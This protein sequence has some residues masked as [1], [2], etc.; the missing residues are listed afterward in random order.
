MKPHE[1]EVLTRRL[2]GLFRMITPEQLAQCEAW[3]KRTPLAA[4]DVAGIIA[5]L[6]AEFEYPKLN[7]FA[8]R[9]KAKESEMHRAE[10]RRDTQTIGQ[11][12]RTMPRHAGKT[13]AQAVIDHGIECA[14]K[15]FG[16]TGLSA[17]GV[18]A[19]G[20]M[21]QANIRQGLI[22]AGIP[23]EDAASEA[24]VVCASLKGRQSSPLPDFP[25]DNGSVI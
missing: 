5:T 4:A 1:V 14:E 12:L 8:A 16:A 18:E 7:I 19:A 21:L 25:R 10:A 15:L 20:N 22:Q 24:A 13:D 23:E 2:E 6:A 11:W 9:I 3:M 17:V